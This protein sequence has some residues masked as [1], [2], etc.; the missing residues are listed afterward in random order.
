MSDA[1]DVIVIGGG[2]SGLSAA[3]LLV[4][5]GLNVVV[6]EARD[7]VGGRTHTV[8]DPSYGGYT[9]VGG[10]YIG[11]TQRRV[12]RLARRFGLEFYK[13]S[14]EQKTV[15]NFAGKWRTYSGTIPPIYNPII[16][17]DVNNLLHTLDALSKQVPAEAPWRAEKA[18][19]W[20]KMTAKEFVDKLCWT[21]FGRD[22]AAIVCRSL[23]SCELHEVSA[24]AFLWYFSSGQGVQRMVNVTN[25]AQERKF[26]GGAQQLSESMADFL[27]D[28]VHLSSPVVRVDHNDDVI[29][30]H[31]WY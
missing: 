24:L 11:P 20:D 8:R 2:I 16:A 10:A 19:V 17:M 5:H 3:M 15:M 7:R 1:K 26:V 23:L 13:I 12:A 21:E 27:G 9:D 22:T 28:R 25:G 18:K 4:E 29:Q 30:V 14:V 6:L 31:R